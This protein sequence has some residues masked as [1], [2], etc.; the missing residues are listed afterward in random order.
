VGGH[1]K[2]DT[3]ERK[4][5]KGRGLLTDALHR[6]GGYV[7]ALTDRGHVALQEIEAQEVVSDARAT[8]SEDLEQAW[9]NGFGSALNATHRR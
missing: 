3:R 9:R 7:G 1:R 6:H 5:L 8:T 4:L 2:P